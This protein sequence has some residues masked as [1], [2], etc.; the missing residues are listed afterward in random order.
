MTGSSSK[1]LQI[2]GKW[3]QDTILKKKIWGQ[4]NAK[5]YSTPLKKGVLCAIL[6]L[7]SRA[8]LVFWALAPRSGLEQVLD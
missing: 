8:Y 7:G 6:L 4:K 3:Y 5:N 2:Q 1:L